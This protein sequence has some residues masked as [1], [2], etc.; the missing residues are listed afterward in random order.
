LSV[1]KW[2]SL[3]GEFCGF[4]LQDLSSHHS[5]GCLDPEDECARL[6]R[7]AVV[8]STATN[9]SHK[10]KTDPVSFNLLSLVHRVTTLIPLLNLTIRD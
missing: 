3:F 9:T 7:K 2:L 5:L 1:D 6:L 4:V 10:K 8:K